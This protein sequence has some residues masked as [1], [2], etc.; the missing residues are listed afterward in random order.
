MLYTKTKNIF[1]YYFFRSDSQ[2]LHRE[3]VD[4]LHRET[5]LQFFPSPFI[6][7]YYHK[8]KTL[9]CLT[10]KCSWGYLSAFHTNKIVSSCTI[11]Y[12]TYI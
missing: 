4:K 9:R 7:E 10:L 12:I 3:D 5:S 8:T 6:Y 1:T 11:N 2:P